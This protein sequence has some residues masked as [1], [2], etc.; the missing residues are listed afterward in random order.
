MEFYSFSI[1]FN[2]LMI[3]GNNNVFQWI[4]YEDNNKNYSLFAD[5]EDLE[6]KFRNN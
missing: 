1:V 3:R 6:F 5:L 4:G 2:E